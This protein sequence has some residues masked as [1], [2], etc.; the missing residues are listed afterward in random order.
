MLGKLM[1]HTTNCLHACLVHCGVC[2][3]CVERAVAFDVVR[4]VDETEYMTNPR[5]T[6]KYDVYR[7]QMRGEEVSLLWQG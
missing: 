2:Y 1:N 5:E 3:K 7:Q 6:E 4:V